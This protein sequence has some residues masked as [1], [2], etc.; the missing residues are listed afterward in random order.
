MGS[1]FWH[2]LNFPAGVENRDNWDY[3][4]VN[5]FLNCFL[6]YVTDEIRWTVKPRNKTK[7][8]PYTINLKEPLLSFVVRSKKLYEVNYLEVRVSCSHFGST[9]IETIV[10]QWCKTTKS[11]IHDSEFYRYILYRVLQNHLESK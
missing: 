6:S 5:F 4:K 3:E 8:W 7:V 9:I 2:G 1:S 11:K 10:S